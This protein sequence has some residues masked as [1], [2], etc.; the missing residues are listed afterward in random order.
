MN[1]NKL[2]RDRDFSFVICRNIETYNNHHPFFSEWRS[3]P[4]AIIQLGKKCLEYDRNGLNIY[5]A[6][7]PVEFVKCSDLKGLAEIFQRKN[8]PVMNNLLG[9]IRE[10]ITYYF[11]RRGW[12]ANVNGE[13]IITL[14]DHIPPESEQIVDILLETS[15]KLGKEK[16]HETNYELGISFLQI[17]D[18]AATREFLAFL[19]DRIVDLGGKD[20]VDA[21]HWRVMQKMSLV[22]LL[23]DAVLD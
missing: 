23:K 8:P 3:A 9:A 2:L 5:W 18:N 13:I 17:G 12:K 6:T 16:E 21:K 14:I 4:S 22:D 19:D 11:S 10:V 20:L 1:T 15:H 7:D